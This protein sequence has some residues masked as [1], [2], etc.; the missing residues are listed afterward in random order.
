MHVYHPMVTGK[1]DI[2]CDARALRPVVCF[3]TNSVI[4]LHAID[5]QFEE[6]AKA[7]RDEGYFQP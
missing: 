7:C 2:Q 3:G 5:N 6:L 1:M 4:K